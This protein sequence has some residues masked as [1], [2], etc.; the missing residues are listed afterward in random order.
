[1]TQP[2]TPSAPRSRWSRLVRE[3]LVHFLVAGA[4]LFALFAA[5][6]PSERTGSDDTTI[7]IDRRALLTFMQYRA[8]AF[9]PDTFGAALDSMSEAER[10][11]LIDAYVEEE[12]LYREAQALGLEQSDYIIRQR[13]VQ[14][15]RFLLG[16][17]SAAGT[18]GTVDEE[19]LADYFTANREAYVVEPSVTFTHV[20]FDAERHGDEAA[21]TLARDAID[22]LN[23]E[24]AGFNDAT[25]LGDRFPFLRNYVERTF[26]YVASHFG[27][28][29]AAALSTVSAADD[30]N[31]NDDRG[32]GAWRGPLRSAY[33]WHAVLV[34]QRTERAY[35]ALDAVRDQVER[36]YARVTGDAALRELTASLRERYRVEVDDLSA[37][38]PDDGD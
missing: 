33:G 16:D 36:D 22:A 3:P 18:G 7:T 26:E 23:A 12:V 34:T 31:H 32:G 5:F 29:F 37:P 10:A 35:A 2:V 15:I 24:G 11:A 6:G 19:A 1:M 30:D 4:A 17:V 14:K 9:E 25:G 20:F 38:T 8:N 21:E 13:M 27:T 28:D